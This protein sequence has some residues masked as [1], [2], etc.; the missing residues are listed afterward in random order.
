ME[1][2]VRLAQDD[3]LYEDLRRRALAERDRYSRKNTAEHIL[4]CFR[5]PA[6]RNRDNNTKVRDFTYDNDTI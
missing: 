6:R 2:V 5:R 3:R 1:V 4:S